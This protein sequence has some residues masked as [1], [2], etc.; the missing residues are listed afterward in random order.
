VPVIVLFTKTDFFDD[1]TIEY[2]LKN[3]IC[4]TIEEAREKASQQDWLGFENQFF[5][6]IGKMK[7]QSKGHVFLRGKHICSSDLLK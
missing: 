2:L 4:Q 1:E 3:K 6:Q 7:Y 5:E